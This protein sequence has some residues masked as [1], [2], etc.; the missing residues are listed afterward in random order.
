MAFFWALACAISWPLFAW[1]DLAPTSWAAFPVPG[2]VKG[3]A[4]AVGPTVSAL[5]SLALFRRTHL[6]TVS[7]WGTSPRRAL[8]FAATPVVLLALFGVPDER[9]HLHGLWVGLL[10]LTYGLLEEAGW[11]GFLQDALRPLAPRRRY[12]VLGL[13]WGAW[14]FTTFFVRGEP[15]DV[16]RTLALMLVVWIGGSWGL[17]VAAD[18]SHAVLVAGTLHIAFN[19]GRALPAERT[20]PLLGISAAV[21]FW[22]LRTWK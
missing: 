4:P 10:F 6:R 18:R 15:A 16:P 5:V 17:G 2:F 9:P 21:W 1:R 8:G 13:L 19:L 20:W 22:L 14:H 12:L 3:L 11:R 7:L